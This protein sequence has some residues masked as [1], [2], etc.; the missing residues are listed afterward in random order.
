MEEFM[1]ERFEGGSGGK[2]ALLAVVAYV[3]AHLEVLE[4][5]VEEHDIMRKAALTVITRP[6]I[7]LRER[8]EDI[9]E[10][11]PPA[12]R[13]TKMSVVKGLDSAN[14]RKRPSNKILRNY[15]AMVLKPLCMKYRQRGVRPR[16][17]DAI[18]SPDNNMLTMLYAGKDSYHLIDKMLNAVHAYA[19]GD[20][21]EPKVKETVKHT[22]QRLQRDGLQTKFGL[23]SICFYLGGDL[24]FLNE[25]FGLA[26]SASNYP[27]VCRAVGNME[28]DRYGPG[29][30]IRS[31]RLT[32]SLSLTPQASRCATF[33]P[34]PRSDSNGATPTR[35]ANAP[36]PAQRGANA[37][38]PAQRGV[39]APRPAQRGANA[40]RPAQRGANAPRPAQRGANAPR[41]AQRGANAPTLGDRRMLGHIF[42]WRCRISASPTRI[43]AYGGKSSSLSPIKLRK[44]HSKTRAFGCRWW[45][46][47]GHIFTWRCRISASPTRISA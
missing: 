31:L 10:E 21:N 44:K 13:P 45:E 27:C 12:E 3:T 17:G 4:Y 23:I 41:P 25:F 14:W 19:P 1:D 16:A 33:G 38:R 2:V 35:G 15:S 28:A 5:I 18:N 11:C 42:P 34:S 40:P 37:P 47:Q 39:N 32:A 20:P 22:L 8:V 6:E 30:E 29:P 36:R 7:V 9:L 43:S 26:G 24:A 46:S